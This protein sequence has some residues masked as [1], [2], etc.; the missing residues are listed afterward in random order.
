MTVLPASG[1]RSAPAGTVTR[2]AGPTATMRPSR[3]TI[4]ALSIGARSV[5]SI[6]R[7]PVNAFV[8]RPV[9]RRQSVAEQHSDR[10]ATRRRDEEGDAISW[11]HYN[12][13]GADHAATTRRMRRLPTF[14]VVLA[15]AAAFLDLY[16]TQPLLPLLTRTFGASTF[17]AG[18]T[19]TAPT[20]A[21][22]I[23]APL[24]RPACRS[25]RAS[26]ASSS[27]SA[28]TL[29]VATAL[30]ATSHE[31]APADLLALRPGHR[32]A[33]AS[34]RAPSPTSTRSGRRRTP[35]APPRRT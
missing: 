28:W 12:P 3:T 1:T 19:I 6:T 22:A 33:R 31:P 35:A 32:H 7:A 29:T 27:L 13:Y 8:A 11:R 34:S 17:E 5:P 24:H 16:S 20:V 23:F 14:P 4:V 21:V 9:L 26:A 25:A 30:A 18:L 2:A 15:G 10:S